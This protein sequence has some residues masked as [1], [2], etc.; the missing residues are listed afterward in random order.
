M[1]SLVDGGVR[2]SHNHRRHRLAEV[3]MRQADDGCLDNSGERVDL[4]LDLLR[5]DIEAAG[6][7]EILAAAGDRDI[8]IMRRSFRDRR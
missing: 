4:G 3:A 5:I 1:A 8:A 2:R 6:D 7:D